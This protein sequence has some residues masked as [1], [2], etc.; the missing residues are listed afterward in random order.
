M[1]KSFTGWLTGTT[2][3]KGTTRTKS[4]EVSRS[5]SVR[6]A[7][8]PKSVYFSPEGADS[9]VIISSNR[10]SPELPPHES[11]TDSY[12]SNT[13]DSTLSR[14]T[15]PEPELKRSTTPEP[16]LKFKVIHDHFSEP[17]NKDK[18]YNEAHKILE[19]GFAKNI[20]N[21]HFLSHDGPKPS[22]LKKLLNR[23]LIL[24]EKIKNSNDLK[25]QEQR[26]KLK[27]FHLWTV[28]SYI[29]NY[30]GA[31]DYKVIFK[32]DES[33]SEKEF[34]SHLKDLNF[35]KDLNQDDLSLILEYIQ[36]LPNPFSLNYGDEYKEHIAC[37]FHP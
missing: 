32:R 33:D 23:I 6:F 9:L 7:T 4:G 28:L 36:C 22:D 35:F 18:D 31:D 29:D 30:R 3:T 15:T 37:F 27:K 20:F 13:P 2:S 8:T 21:H 26:S 24:E 11:S 1:I 19:A 10:S 12:R 25:S 14:T 5:D 16:F 34:L 17:R